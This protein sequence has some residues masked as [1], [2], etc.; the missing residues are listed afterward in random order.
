MPPLDDDRESKPIADQFRLCAHIAHIDRRLARLRKRLAFAK[1]P[2]EM[3]IERL[4]REL[5]AVLVVGAP[6]DGQHLAIARPTLTVEIAHEA[7]AQIGAAEE[8]ID[9]GGIVAILHD[10]SVRRGEGRVLGEIERTAGLEEIDVDAILRARGLIVD[11]DIVPGRG[12]VERMGDQRLIDRHHAR[13][14]RNR[15]VAL[16]QF[17]NENAVGRVDRQRGA[18]SDAAL[19]AGQRDIERPG[20]A[21]ALAQQADVNIARRKAYARRHGKIAEGQAARV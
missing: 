1:Q 9:D 5:P 21:R 14:R 8:L 16:A 15:R 4:D 20:C 10:E 7:C 2:L 12:E 3:K 13:I 19:V 11:P 17:G 18:V 6:F